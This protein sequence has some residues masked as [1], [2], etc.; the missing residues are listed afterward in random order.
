VALGV[1][2]LFAAAACGSSRPGSRSAEPT[3]S[4]SS[5]PRQPG[6]CRGWVCRPQRTI[7]LASGYTITLWLG[8]DQRDYR[9]RPVLE[10]RRGGRPVQAWVPP[11]GDGWNGSLT[12]RDRGLAPNCVL[13]DSLGMHASIAEVVILAGGRLVHPSGAEAVAD[14]GEMRAADLDGD[15]Y[16]DIV[17]TTNDYQPN[18]AQGH[19]YWQTSRY[20]AG[21]FVV[22]GCTRQQGT[23]PPARLLTAPCP[24]A[25]LR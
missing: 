20:R 1:A 19:D 3:S 6:A 17:A 5:A 22:T 13:I 4:P 25:L 24:P 11:R 7:L 14:S 21:R 8:T 15:G 10:L 23:P 2:L 9:S 18:Y 16:L 12:C